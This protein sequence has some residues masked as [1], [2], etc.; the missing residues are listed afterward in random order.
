MRRTFVLVAVVFFLV[1]F[2]GAADAEGPR[3]SSSVR[4]V[5]YCYVDVDDDGF[6]DENDPGYESDAGCPSGEVDNNDDCDDDDD[7]IHPYATETWYD[8]IDQDCDGWNDY[9]QDKDTYV[10]ESYNAFVG[11]TSPFEGDCDDIDPNINPGAT[12]TCGDGVDSDCDGVGGPSG[13]EDGDGCSWE[14]ENVAG[15]SDCD[16]DSD[17]DDLDD[18]VEMEGNCVFDAGETDPDDAD[19]DNDGAIDGHEVNTMGT[20]PLDADSD[21]DGISDHMED[22]NHDGVL[23]VTETDPMDADTDDDGLSDGE[24]DF[25]GDGVLDSWETNPLDMDTDCDLLKDGLELGRSTPVPGGV[26]DG[27]ALP[28]SGTAAGWQADTH[29]ASTT[30]PGDPDTDN[31]GVNDGAEDANQ[32]GAVD[33][34]ETDPVDAD[35]DDDGL[36]DGEE[37]ALGIDPTVADTDFDLLTDGLELGRMF[38]VMSGYSD[39]NST[40]Y[41][42]TDVSWQHDTDS[43]TTTDPKLPDT[44]DDWL[45]DG[46]ED[47]NGDGFKDTDETDPNLWDTDE[48][49]YSDGFE[50]LCGSDPLDPLS[51]PI[52]CPIFEDGFELGNLEAWSSW[53]L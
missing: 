34:D 52:P 30:D 53:V 1:A 37:G 51:L 6:G 28:Y 12:D 32:N 10:D 36:P 26:S 44:D 13:D 7:A 31:D 5:V 18:N 2:A 29:P 42:G 47:A 25:D 22:D 8:G 3:G 24:E 21:N 46:E 14:Q 16:L 43:A 9:D 39:W 20:D 40:P 48:D 50:V 41:L 27:W 49:S 11:G 38:G 17:D 19:S 45:D 4:I 35:T 15:S 33:V 23:G